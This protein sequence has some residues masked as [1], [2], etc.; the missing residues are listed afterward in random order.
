ML[1][2]YLMSLLLH[3]PFYFWFLTLKAHSKRF[4]R[5]RQCLNEVGSPVFCNH[6]T[7]FSDVVPS[8]A[9][10]FFSKSRFQSYSYSFQFVNKYRLSHRKASTEIQLN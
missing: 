10:F 7:F 3:K 4:Q 8:F 6:K 1:S 9:S 2:V 5:L